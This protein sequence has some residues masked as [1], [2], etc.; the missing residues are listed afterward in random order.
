LIGTWFPGISSSML[1]L[2]V[3][4][5]VYVH[6][7]H[8]LKVEWIL[9]LVV[10]EARILAYF[11]GP[12]YL[13]IA[14]AKKG[15]VDGMVRV[16]FEQSTLTAVVLENRC[17]EGDFVIQRNPSGN[18]FVHSLELCLKIGNV[19]RHAC[20]RQHVCVQFSHGKLRR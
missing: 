1:H 8:E 2:V 12:H 17:V 9:H 10:H 13:A 14:R 11:W 20:V 6:S 15:F 4:E 16:G 5:I 7:L 19:L 3:K 18:W